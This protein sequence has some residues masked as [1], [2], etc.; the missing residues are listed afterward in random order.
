M[1][2]S[3]W[4]RDQERLESYALPKLAKHRRH[5]AGN[6]MGSGSCVFSW[7]HETFSFGVFV[8]GLNLV[9]DL[10]YC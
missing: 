1:V 4:F 10:H 6:I 8:R 2:Q 7:N 3:Q 9:C 5:S